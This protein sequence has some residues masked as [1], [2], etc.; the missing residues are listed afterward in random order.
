MKAALQE[1]DAMLRSYVAGN[2][3]VAAVLILACWGFFMAMR[4]DYPFLAAIVSGVLSLVPYLGAVLA[5][6][7]PFLIGA[8]RWRTAAAPYL[9][10]AG[11]L[12]VLHI[13]AMNVLIPAIVGRRVHL[14]A[15][16]VTM[17]LLFW[18]WM[19]GAMGLL[20]AIP[21]TATAKV[22]CDHVPAWR[23]AG[24]WLGA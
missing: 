16:A 18:G 11:V 13:L 22:V 9:A 8:V 23:P 2:A 20:L 7:P 5:W 15:L 24:R 10:V 17:A 3:L 19:W 12:S 1:M 14:N 6:L 21:I 4:L